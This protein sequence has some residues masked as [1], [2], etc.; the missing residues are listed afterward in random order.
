VFALGAYLGGDTLA[1]RMRDFDVGLAGREHIYETARGIARDYPLFGIGPGAF[2][3]VFQLYRSSEDEFWPAELHNDWLETRITFG[4]LG[5]GF[6]AAA[7]LLVLARWF[8]PRGI[9][10]GWRLAS[11]L[12]LAL[13]GC[14]VHARY[15]FPFQIYSLQLLFLLLCAILFCLSRRPT[16]R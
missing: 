8:L 15:D 7:L 6:I 5:S 14:L 13:A 12:W 1:E 11:L 16:A 2:E 3:P 9:Q 10:T 4:W